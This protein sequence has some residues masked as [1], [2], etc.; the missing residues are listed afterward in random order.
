MPIKTNLDKLESAYTRE[1]KLPSCGL[2]YRDR[3]PDFPETVVISPYSY[4]TEAILSTNLAYTSK[5]A[6]IAGAVVQNFPPEFDPMDLL[7]GD[8]IVIVAVA[9]GLTYGETLKYAALCPKCGH[10]EF[11]TVKVPEELTHHTWAGFKSMQEVLQKAQILLPKCKD[12]LAFR[13]L[14]IR[15]EQ[16]LLETV[17]VTKKQVSESAQ[18][19]N[20]VANEEVMKI[21]HRLISVNQGAPDNVTEAAN[22][23]ARIRGVDM[24]HLNK[25]LDELEPGINLTHLVGCEK[26]SHQYEATAPVMT[27]FFR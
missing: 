9:R 26:C 19:K 21:A 14:S 20:A 6:T 23:V 2:P 27:H 3:F 11:I 12:K 8:L 5:L 18:T 24:V 16:Q 4:Q 13:F 10:R 7:T 17:S 1:Y 22:Y 25:T 15:E